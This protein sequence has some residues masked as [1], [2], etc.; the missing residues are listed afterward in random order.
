MK[1]LVQ[2]FSTHPLLPGS[3]LACLMGDPKTRYQQPLDQLALDAFNKT[4]L[5]DLVA[6]FQSR[7]MLNDEQAAIQV[8]Y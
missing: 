4:S 5:V 6:D 2:D 1:R 8:I 3:V 7:G